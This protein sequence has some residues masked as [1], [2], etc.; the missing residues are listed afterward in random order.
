M[1]ESVKHRLITVH[2]WTIDPHRIIYAT[3]LLMAA[4][5]IFDPTGNPALGS[6]L[7]ELAGLVAAPLVAVSLAHGFSDALD[8]QIRT[9]HRLNGEDRKHLLFVATQ[10]V[11]VGVP[12]IVI[13][14]FLSLAGHDAREAVP[15]GLVLGVASLFFWGAFAARTAD[16][17]IWIQVR[18]ACGYGLL[19]S[20]VILLELL[21]RH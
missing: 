17:G 4:L 18:W 21:I 9:G 2:G 7:V 10:Y 14:A 16:L 3:I 8:I 1:D 12:V 15:A 11:L 5:A 13:G 19:G 6:P 20:V